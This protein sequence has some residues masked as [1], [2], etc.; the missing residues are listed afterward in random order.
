[1]TLT[2]IV[3]PIYIYLVPEFWTIVY[4]NKGLLIDFFN[5]LVEPKDMETPT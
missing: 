1:M 5:R 3:R 4:T 2:T